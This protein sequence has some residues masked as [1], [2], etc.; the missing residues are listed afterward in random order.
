[1]KIHELLAK[2]SSSNS[3]EVYFVFGTRP[4]TPSAE[5]ALV[6]EDDF[7][8]FSEQNPEF[9]DM[10]SSQETRSIIDVAVTNGLCE[11]DDWETLAH[12]FAFYFARDAFAFERADLERFRW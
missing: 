4:F 9:Q 6:P 10:L 11:S 12:A 7:D 1:M 8:L 2:L 5:V 3:A